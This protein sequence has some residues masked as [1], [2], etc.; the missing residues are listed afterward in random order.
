MMDFNLSPFSVLATQGQANLTMVVKA[1]AIFNYE[2]QHHE[3]LTTTKEIYGQIATIKSGENDD[4]TVFL[5]SKIK[6][7]SEVTTDIGNA[8][9]RGD[10]ASLG[11]RGPSPKA[12]VAIPTRRN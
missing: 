8:G 1:Q 12:V 11:I 9:K 5:S 10:E 6:G 2:R 7:D 3:H 4:F